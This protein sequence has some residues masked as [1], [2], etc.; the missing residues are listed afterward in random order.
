M[1]LKNKNIHN[2][3]DIYSYGEAKKGIFYLIPGLCL[4]HKIFTTTFSKA[5]YSWVEYLVR[6]GYEVH[7]LN[8]QK[9]TVMSL[10]GFGE[11]ITEDIAEII[12]S[13]NSHCH[14]VTHSTS[15]AYGWKLMEKTKLIDTII[16]IAPA[17]PGNIQSK[18]IID[19]LIFPLSLQSGDY[20]YFIEKDGYTPDIDWVIDKLVAGAPN[21]RKENYEDLLN[22]CRPC[23]IK[24]ILERF[25]IN[26]SQISLN[27][28]LLHQKTRLIVVTGDFDPPHSFET[29][30]AIVSYFKSLGLSAD[31]LWLPEYGLEGHG[32]TFMMEEGSNRIL[33]LVISK[34]I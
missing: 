30:N 1:E 4:S 10:E 14:V 15:G 18:K 20:T 2:N 12:N 27:E 21:F 17:P 22:L 3:I 24:S 25:N 34:I 31:F 28:E 13:N 19:P 6:L 29:D 16:A 5:D 32:H 33:D 9:Y 8:W 7:V 23:H 11:L 26:G